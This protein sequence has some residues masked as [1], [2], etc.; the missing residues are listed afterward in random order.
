MIQCAGASRLQP[1]VQKNEANAEM[2]YTCVPPSVQ[3][4]ATSLVAKKS[5]F[6]LH[7][8]YDCRNEPTSHLI[9]EPS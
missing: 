1:P 8:Y 7:L 6:V 2:L 9:Y 3:P 4:V 5:L